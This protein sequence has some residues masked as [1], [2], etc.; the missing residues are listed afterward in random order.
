MFV[1]KINGVSNLGFKGYQHVKNNVG[2]TIM[3]FNYPYD[4]DKETCEVQIFRAV[5]T[6]KYNYK[7][8]ETPITSFFL[9]PEGVEVN[10]QDLTNLDKDAPFAYKI[11]RKDKESGKVIYEGP[12]TGVK[13]KQ[14]GNE[15]GFR[16]HNDNNTWYQIKDKDGKIIKAYEGYQDPVENYKYTLVTR[17]GTTPMVQ[18]AG[19]LITPDSLMPGAM[20]RGFKEEN[21]GEIY[22]DKEYQKRMEG[23]IKTFSN[24]YGGSIAGAQRIIPYLKQNGYK[25]MF[26]TPIANGSKGWSLGYWNKNNMQISPNMGNTENF[27]SFFRD[28]YAN[29]MKYVY[30]GTFTS[31]GLEGIHFQYALRWA[32]QKP[33]SYY[34]FRM[35]GLKNSNLGLG[36]VPKNK[37]NLRHRV[38]NAPYNYELQS[39]G[40]YKEVANPN[41][42]KNKETL[43]QIYD[44]SQ[45]SDEQL[46]KLDKAI[47]NYEKLTSGNELAINNHDDTIINF[48]F[49]INPNEYRNRINVINELNKNFEKHIQLDTPDGTIIACEFSNFKIDKKT[50]GGF[51]TWDANTDM[52]KMNYHISGYDEKLL[53]AIPDRAKRYQEQQMI[54]RGAR[55]VQDMAIQAGKYWTAKVNDIQK[56]YIAQTIGGVKTVDGINKLIEEGKLPQ[57]AK[58]SDKVLNNILNAQYLLKAKGNLPKDDVTVKSLMKMPLDALEFGENTVGVLATSYFSNRATTDDTIGISRFDLMKKGNP[59][60]VEPYNKNYKKVNSMFTNEIKE[61]A[62]KII[63]EVNNYSNEKLLDSNGDYTEY[64]EYVIELVGQDIAKYAFLK[65]LTGDKLKTKLLN[66]GEITYDYDAIKKETTLKALNINAHNP[67]DE[68]VILANKM[69][70][71][72]KSL[73]KEDISYVASSINKRIAGTDTTSFR[74]AEV[75]QERSDLGLAWRL[76]AAKDTMDMDA[77]RNGDNDF[78]DTWDDA[79]KFWKK[80]VQG[81]K[82]ENP[83][84]YIV[85]EITDIPDLMRSTYGANSCPYN[86]ETNVNNAKFNG[87]PDAQTKFMNE[88]GITS[89]AGYSYFF[90]DLLTIFAPSFDEGNG[91]SENHDRFRNR[92]D[93]LLQTRSVDYL[94]NLYTFMGN[95]DKPRLLHGLALDMKLFHDNGDKIQHRLDALQV[96]SDSKSIDEMPIELKLNAANQEYFRTLSTKAVAMSKLLKD[97]LNN[98]IGNVVSD[99]DKKLINSAIVDLTNGNYLGEGVT[100]NFQIINIKELSSIENA[101]NE[102]I[103][104]AEEKHGLKLTDKEKS[105]LLAS[106]QDNANKNFRN[107]LVKGQLNSEDDQ[108]THNRKLVSMLLNKNNKLEDISNS[109]VSNKDGFNQYNLYTVNLAALIRDSY[110]ASG[111]ATNAKDSIFSAVKDFVE[112]YDD[113]MVK[114][115]SSELPKIEDPIIGRRKNGYAARDIRTAISMAIKQAEYKSG[116]EIAN[117]E[118]IIDNVYKA[119]TEPAEAKAE[120]IMEY[121]KGF[122]GIPTMYAG[123]ELAMSGYEEKAKNIYLQNRNALPWEQ[124]NEDNLIGNYRKTVMGRMNETLKSRSNNELQALNNGTPYALDVQVNSMNRDAVQ[125]RIYQINDE[126]KNKS[127][128][129]KTRASLESERRELSKQLAK[130]AY[131]MQNANGDMTITL[132]NAGDVDYG[133]RVDY[134]AKYGLDTEDKRKKFFEENNIDS[135]N[136][137]NRYVPILPK[138]EV[139]SILLAAGISIP[140]GTV[141][142]NANARDKAKYVVKDLGNGMRGIVKEGGGK[143]IMDGLTSK[144]G[145][146]ILKHIKNIVFKGN[147]HREYYNPQYNFVSNPYK[148]KEIPVE[149]EKLSLLSK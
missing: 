3:K 83:N 19:Y 44:A 94:R 71:G 18:G 27:A 8:D 102:I 87:D 106:I 69:Q 104:I 9:K 84:S 56:M 140:I 58:I 75:L 81:V 77:V 90:T 129:S 141:F 131:M 114:S 109:T 49:Q 29:G 108:G 50:E 89:E 113:N 143:I 67:E 39:N 128:D 147:K 66:N 100:N 30:D 41:Y 70:K 78:N 10:L 119:A 125:G 136:P 42:N 57:E 26:S 121:L 38:I 52:V 138:S 111:K 54:E 31:E 55:E 127:L 5:P 37:E 68:A 51:V 43:V 112:K 130:V 33:Q 72:L 17:N 46:G 142:T 105:E 148:Q 22:Y 133:N 21:T 149:G 60:L 6:E 48:V 82:S 14:I 64:G 11:V 101:F 76:D 126:L 115:N 61:F 36:T 53:Q 73:T 123:D 122:F 117:K 93:L 7:I 59:H 110:I 62:D 15:Y 25:L 79:I 144:N 96:L 16:V 74:I 91:E 28:L 120:M 24:I 97:V 63:K 146:M 12:D 107:Y 95:H 88:T 92:M 135:I 34:W 145:V 98:D 2:E 99:E 85:A 103:K 20:Y 65:S 137:N 32:E 40:T 80:F 45:A 132:M 4:S 13:I 124:L 116:K 86:G 139:D 47:E 134:F 35:S 118:A 23:V 1:N